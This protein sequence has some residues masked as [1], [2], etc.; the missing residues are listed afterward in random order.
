MILD[1]SNICIY[2]VI[3]TECGLE[4]QNTSIDLRRGEEVVNKN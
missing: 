2:D 4:R 3:W 1:Y